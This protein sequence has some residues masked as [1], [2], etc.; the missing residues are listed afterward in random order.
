[1]SLSKTSVGMAVIVNEA[2]TKQRIQL[3]PVQE[4]PVAV[5]T[6]LSTFQLKLDE[7]ARA[8][9]GGFD[10]PDLAASLFAGAEAIAPGT[11]QSAHS[12]QMAESV[13]LLSRVLNSSLDL[14]QNVVNPMIDRVVQKVSA[15]IDTAVQA[16]QSPL[17]IVQ[18]RSDAIFDSIYLQESVS[19]YGT[20]S[21]EIPLKSYG[22]PASDVLAR[23]MTGHAGMDAQLVEFFARM[24]EDFAISV[25]NRLFC[26]AS[27]SSTEVYARPSQK[28]EAVL[29]YFFAAKAGVEIPDGLNV[30]LSEWRAYCSNILASAGAS[31][32]ASYDA[33]ERQRKYGR[34]VLE[35]PSAPEPVGIVL[36]DGDKYSDW[37]AQ[38]GTPELIFA[39]AY[40]D[41][42]FDPTHLLARADALKADWSHVL[43]MFQNAVA[44]RRFDAM[45]SG[46]KAAITAEINDLPEDQLVGDRATYHEKL[47][48]HCTCAKQRDLSDLWH[49]A[50]KAVC[51]VV[52][53]QTDAEA[54]LLAIDE[55][56]KIHPEKPVRELALYA[57]IE[58]VA[59]WLADQLVAEQH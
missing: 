2:I 8:L 31:I 28:N 20:Q 32:V 21:R 24:G 3:H 46:L 58:I 23:L 55:Q 16:A 51:R 38:G 30:E 47:R 33:R 49:F 37:L 35:C 29:A 43:G 18:V 53:P 40:G 19:R 41:G 6:D 17:E 15:A 9:E 11:E 48:E 25:W 44:F 39:A 57:T 54:L 13:Q 45:V 12:V 1:M 4:T 42:N 50:R 59:R 56:S 34:M 52:F 36:V 10:R 22:V 27:A 7:S 26:S 14:T 5:L